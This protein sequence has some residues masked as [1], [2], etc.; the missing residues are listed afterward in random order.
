MA[1]YFH[2]VELDVGEHGHQ[3]T[4][5]LDGRELKGVRRVSFVA[6]ARDV[7]AGRLLVLV[8]RRNNL[9]YFDGNYTKLGNKKAIR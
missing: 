3:T 5:R 1:A 4:I 7:T 9:A 2:R 6:D 8:L